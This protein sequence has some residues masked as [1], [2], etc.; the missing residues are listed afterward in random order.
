[1]L[2][3]ETKWALFPLNTV[4]TTKPIDS[5]TEVSVIRGLPPANNV[6]QKRQNLVYS[7][8]TEKERDHIH[9]T[10]TTVDCYTCFI[11]LLD[12]VAD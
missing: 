7:R 9:I 4:G 1:M 3:W 8:E 12:T 2:N 5:V 10:F 6:E 11:F